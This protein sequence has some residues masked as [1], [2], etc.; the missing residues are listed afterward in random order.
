MRKAMPSS[1]TSA[2]PVHSIGAS[3]RRWGGV[4]AWRLRTS[5]TSVDVSTTTATKVDV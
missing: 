4:A 1:A 2:S 5:S 3:A